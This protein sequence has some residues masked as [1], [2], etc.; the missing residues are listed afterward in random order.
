MAQTYSDGTVVDWADTEEDAEYPAPVLYVNDEP[1]DDHH[2]G[3][4]RSRR[5]VVGGGRSAAVG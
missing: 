2:A 1:A 3:A 4:E 5:E